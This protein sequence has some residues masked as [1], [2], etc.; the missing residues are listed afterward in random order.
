M[1]TQ[2]PNLT[3]EQM[4]ILI[5]QLQQRLETLETQPAQPNPA[6]IPVPAAAP[7]RTWKP[8]RPPIYTGKKSD[9][10]DSWVFKVEEYCDTLHIPDGEQVRFARTLLQDHA[11]TWWRMISPQILDL[12]DDQQW[13]QFKAQLKATFQP[14][15]SKENARARLD[16]LKQTTSVLMYN[17]AFREIMMELPNMDEEDRIHIYI[18]G[19]KSHVASQVAMHGPTTLLEAQRLADTADTIHF[20]YTSRPNTTQTRYRNEYKGP[21]PM[22]LDAIGKLTPNERERLRRN[23]GCFR[24][25]Q[26]GHLARDCPMPN[27]RPPQINATET[28]ETEDSGKE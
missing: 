12:P 1:A 21:A 10:L 18:K 22:D 6:L 16:K 19:L 25:R 28:L 5:G 15:N 20:Q 13:D 3:A 4:A 26:L 7:A 9:A 14:T 8:E 24:C 2:T 23:G 11:A 27:R 17:S